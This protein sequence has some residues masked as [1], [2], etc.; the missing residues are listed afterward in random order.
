MR[1]R[2]RAHDVQRLQLARLRRFDH[3]GCGLARFRRNHSAPQSF[4]SF[5]RARIVNVRVA[6]QAVRQQSHVGRAA[7]IRVIAQRHVARPARQF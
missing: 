2:I 1:Q 6:R 5:A 3:L 4:E 7:R